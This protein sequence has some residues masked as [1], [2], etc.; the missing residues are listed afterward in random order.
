MAA[1]GVAVERE[2]DTLRV[3]AEQAGGAWLRIGAEPGAA[4]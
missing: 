1:N 4:R 2:D 3:A